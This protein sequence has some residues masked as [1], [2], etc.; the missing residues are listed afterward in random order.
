MPLGIELAAAWVSMLP[1]AEIA[2]EIE[3]TIGFLETTMRDVPERHRSLRAA[4]DHSWHLLTDVQRR[5]FRQLSIFRGPFTREA[6]AAV[7]GADLGLL[8]ELVAKSLV[9]RLEL[10]RYE[11]HE[12]LRQYAAERLAEEAD[13]PAEVRERHARYYVGRLV[14]RRALLV[15]PRMGEARDE[16]R[17]DIA[18]FGS[19]VEWAATQWREDEARSAF[20]ALSEFY[21]AHS[22]PE[23]LDTFEHL[24]ELLGY[25]P[26]TSFDAQAAPSVLL[27]ALA[28]QVDF[29]AYIGY[30]E[31]QDALARTCAPEFRARGLTDELGVCLLALGTNACYVDDYPEAVTF[32]EESA[33]VTGTAGDSWSEAV[34]LS[35]LGFVRL[36]QNELEPA[37]TAFEA[38]YEVALNMGQ[39][40]I[41][42]FALSKLGLLADASGDYA[43]AMRLHTEANGCFEAVGD[44][45]GGG[46]ALSRASVS[47]YCL[48]DYEE[49]LRLGRAG[50]D[51]FAD[52]NHRWGM[53]GA[54]SRVGFALV[55]LGDP[56]GAREPLRS[57]LEQAQVTEAKSLALLALSGVGVL[58]A[59]EGENRRA[60][61]LLRFVFDYPGFPPLYFITAKPEL[62]RLE[63]ELAPEEL[64]AAGEA[65]R[66]AD[67]DTVVAA[68]EQVLA[69]RSP[70]LRA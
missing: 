2:D 27:S 49:A 12:L 69:D 51:A 4:F 46:Y 1:C 7:A 54:A 30:D 44:R 34:A 5:C 33:A 6:A 39:P 20:H 16:L 29:A 66:A 13:E 59:R 10:G 31:A 68:A 61:E 64:A 57:A 55:A 35:W 70:A 50:Y 42:A 45:G 53:I 41:R 14:D 60:Y 15:G 9:R 52:V 47:A 25:S 43:E 8:A 3:R 22:W 63:A 38:S 23:G 19:A 21:A 18:N 40:L 56:N 58:L 36:L 62:D 11:L 24:A 65:A 48:G 32:L 17:G 26:A 67:F 37:R 28:G